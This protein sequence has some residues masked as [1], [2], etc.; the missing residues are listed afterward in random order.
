MSVKLARGIVLGRL[1]S[2]AAPSTLLK[3][4]H[5]LWLAAG[6]SRKSIVKLKG[7]YHWP[8]SLPVPP[9]FR[10]DGQTFW[11]PHTWEAQ[12]GRQN[13]IEVCILLDAAAGPS[14][15][16]KTENAPLLGLEADAEG[17]QSQSASVQGTLFSSH[18]IE[19]KFTFSLASPVR[20]SL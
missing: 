5:I 17:W 13:F 12:T 2:D 15:R 14:F 11:L 9:T 1:Y 7:N 8:F 19:V 3:T 16:I 4:K 20:Q 10:K 18:T 6:N